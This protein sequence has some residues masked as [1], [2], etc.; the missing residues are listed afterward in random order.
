MQDWN[1]EF[2]WQEINIRNVAVCNDAGLA[3]YKA[4]YEQ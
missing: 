1:T 2:G 4:N 3:K